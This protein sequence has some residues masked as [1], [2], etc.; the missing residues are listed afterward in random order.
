MSRKNVRIFVRSVLGTYA[1]LALL[2]VAGF[3]WFVRDALLP[4]SPPPRSDGIVA[5]TGG[6][7]RIDTSIRLLEDGSARILLVSGVD[8]HVQLHDLAPRL[9]PALAARI[10]LGRRATSTVGN[11]METALW[12][13]SHDVHRLIVVTAGYHMRRALLEISRAAPGVQ[14]HAYPVRPPALGRPFSRTSLRLL[15]F[16]YAKFLLALA[17]PTK[18]FRHPVDAV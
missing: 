14:L 4:P 2:M 16:E 13:H 8:P 6:N 12:V 7:G 9:D 15:A 10:T 18:F 1:A 5:L 17:A 11:A 3:A